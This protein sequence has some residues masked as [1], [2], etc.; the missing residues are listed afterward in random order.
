MPL[1]HLSW[2]HEK[3]QTEVAAFHTRN[4]F[5][6]EGGFSH[7]FRRPVYQDAALK[8]YVTSLEDEFKVL[9]NKHG[10]GNLII[11]AQDQLFQT[12]WN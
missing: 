8:P 9:Y 6:S 5:V 11:A 7:Y 10:R 12:A 1:R 2:R 3:L 4:G